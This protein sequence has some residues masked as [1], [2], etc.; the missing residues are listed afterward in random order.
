M[1][2][3]FET[4]LKLDLGC[5][6]ACCQVCKTFWSATYMEAPSALIVQEQFVGWMTCFRSFIIKPVVLPQVNLSD[7]SVGPAFSSW[8]TSNHSDP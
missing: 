2:C 5:H 8:Y 1:A 6:F 4:G 7:C 3:E